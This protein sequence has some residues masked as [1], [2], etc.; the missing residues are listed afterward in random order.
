[1]PPN[2]NKFKRLTPS[3]LVKN[4][5]KLSFPIR[6]NGKADKRMSLLSFKAKFGCFHHDQHLSPATVTVTVNLNWRL[7]AFSCF[8]RERHHPALIATVRLVLVAY[9]FILG[10]ELPLSIVQWCT[11]CLKK[12][13]WL[14]H[15]FGKYRLIFKLLSLT[16][17]QG[18]SV[19]DYCRV[20][21]LILAVLLHYL[22]KFACNYEP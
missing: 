7:F 21:Q 6:F 11:L 18:N 20:F 17:S 1:M 19:R 16:Y 22:A 2:N 4:S 14:N 15:N 8:L 3:D 10:Y 9:P 5:L 13:T 12:Y